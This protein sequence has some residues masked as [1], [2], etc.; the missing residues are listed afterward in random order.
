MG[1][2]S[3]SVRRRSSRPFRTSADA[4]T[5][6]RIRQSVHDWAAL[7]PDLLWVIDGPIAPGKGN[8]TE[9]RDRQVGA[10]LVRKGLVSIRAEGMHVRARAGQ[11]LV[12]QASNVAQSVEPGTILLSLRCLLGWPNRKPMF[13]GGPLRV[14]SA[15]DHPELERRAAALLRLAGNRQLYWEAPMLHLADERIEFGTFIRYQR[16]LFEWVGALVE[17]MESETAGL[18]AFTTSDARLTR[19]IRMLDVLPPREPFPGSE[20]ERI[21]GVSLS[22]VNRLCRQEHGC[23][24]QQYRERRR[25]ERATTGVR[26]RAR[27]TKEIAYELG[28]RQLSHFSAWFKRHTGQPPRA[29]RQGPSGAPGGK[30]SRAAG[31]G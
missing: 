1:S 8:V 22:Q 17:A 18:Q 5:P 21:C 12:C 2:E 15:R 19:C 9:R 29:Y 14:L 30:P 23:S 16:A 7:Q 25:L 4:S 26:E 6:A 31:D 10:I 24:L 28:F 13:R 3:D 11:W 20:I 27:P